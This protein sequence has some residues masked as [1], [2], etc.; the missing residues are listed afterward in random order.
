[1]TPERWLACALAAVLGVLW[2]CS[3]KVPYADDLLFT[4]DKHQL[5]TA[6]DCK[7]C[8][9]EVV[10]EWADSPHAHAWTSKQ[11]T[12]LTAD[13]AA[14]SCLGCHAP[15][16]LGRDGEIALRAD[17]REEGVTCVTC[18]L[19]PDANA[20][21][22]T[23]RGPHARTSPV[24]VH[25]IVVDDLFRKAELCGTCHTDVLEQWRAAPQPEDGSEKKICQACHMP[26][27]RRTIESVDP[28]RAYSRV[29]VAMGK[30]VE[31]RRHRFDI[32]REP[33]KDVE[34][35][36]RRV[37]DRFVVDVRNKTPHAIPTGA[38]GRREV[39]L[40]AGDRAIRLRADLDEAIPAGQVRTFELEA[41]ATSEV[42]LERRNPRTG[43]YERLAP[44][45]PAVK[46]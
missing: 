14:E 28:D 16:P 4:L 29:L 3:V 7:R 6:E 17:H 34:L 33:W 40:R 13:H 10:A 27:V 12:M 25:P 32:P 8:H 20:A 2:A 11:F 39:R 1:M 5:P 24:E 46:P 31:G 37:G 30:P 42:V 38:F 22:L 19:V 15:A 45:T 9:G 36:T 35:D 18:H 41:P 43:E 21:P 26:S 23:M 44:E